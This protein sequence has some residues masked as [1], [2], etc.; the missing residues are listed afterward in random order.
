VTIERDG[1]KCVDD[2]LLD[3]FFDGETNGPTG[4]KTDIMKLDDF[5]DDDGDDDDDDD[6]CIII[7]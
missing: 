2:D 4:S 5:K 3:D 7:D 1:M 6:D